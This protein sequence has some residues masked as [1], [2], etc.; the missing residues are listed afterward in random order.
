LIQAY[1]QLG[2][3]DKA[4]KI[5]RLLLKLGPDALNVNLA[6]MSVGR[7]LEVECKKAKDALDE[8]QGSGEVEAAKKKYESYQQLLG[9]LLESLAARE[10]LTAAS[11]VWLAQ[12]CAT[13]DMTD[14]AEQVARTYFKRMENDANFIDEGEKAVTRMRTLLVSL[15]RQKK[16]YAEALDQVDQL[17]AAHP[18]VLEP[19]MERGWILQAWAERKPEKYPLAVSQWERLRRDLERVGIQKQKK[20]PKTK[21]EKPRELYDVT[22]NEAFCLYNWAKKSGDKEKAKQ[23][24]QLLKQMTLLDPNLNG[25]DTVSRFNALCDKVE[26][27]MGL[28]P[29]SKKAAAARKVE[30]PKTAAPAGKP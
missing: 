22:Y 26:I 27:L 17:I 14:E 3:M 25:P 11:T 30:A 21:A 2:E 18:N 15:L 24:L 9:E 4:A 10:K 20:T 1:V 13:I 8:A 7:R 5:G 29:S 16:K 19:R 6:L 12:A 28:E 23:A